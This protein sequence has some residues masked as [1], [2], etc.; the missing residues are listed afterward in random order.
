[1]RM[2]SIAKPTIIVNTDIQALKRRLETIPDIWAKLSV[3]REISHFLI[4]QEVGS[5]PLSV[6][7]FLADI[8][9][10]YVKHPV[11]FYDID[12]LF[13]PSIQI[14]PLN[15]FRQIGRQNVLIIFWPGTFVG[16]TLVYAQ[17]EHHHYRFWKNVNDVEIIG[18]NDAIQ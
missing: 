12:I 15:L 6:S 3:G 9:V 1:M 11:V 4:S 2:I 14:D 7:K 16:D 10:L 18:A 13:E 8:A 17:P 5:Y